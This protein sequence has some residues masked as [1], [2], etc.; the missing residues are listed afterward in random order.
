MPEQPGLFDTEGL[1]AELELTVGEGPLVVPARN[2]FLAGILAVWVFDGKPTPAQ[3]NEL[4]GIA[5]QAV[6]NAERLKA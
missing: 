6:A 1:A 2:G 4:L 3:K 5:R